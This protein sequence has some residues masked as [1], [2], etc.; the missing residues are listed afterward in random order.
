M[1]GDYACVWS[2]ISLSLSFFIYI[3]SVGV[4][5]T[6]NKQQWQEKLVFQDETLSRT[7]LIYVCE[8][9]TL[10]QLVDW[11]VD[12][13]QMETLLFVCYHII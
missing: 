9:G 11:A 2:C 10:L 7:R 5:Q 1:R 4:L 3:Q 8:G 13:A 6:T 12:K